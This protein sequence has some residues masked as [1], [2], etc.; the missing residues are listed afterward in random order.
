MQLFAVPPSETAGNGSK[1]GAFS[2]EELGHRYPLTLRLAHRAVGASGS[3][4][5]R[6]LHFKER[7]AGDQRQ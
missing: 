6:H 4:L 7:L 5:Q 1:T 3:G 2:A